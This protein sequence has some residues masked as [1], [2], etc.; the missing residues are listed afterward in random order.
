MNAGSILQEFDKRQES[1]TKL[2]EKYI[3]EM[4]DRDIDYYE[5][6]RKYAEKMNERDIEYGKRFKTLEGHQSNEDLAIEKE[7]TDGAKD[8]VVSIAQKY[9][10]KFTYKTGRNFIS[11]LSNP[12]DNKKLI[13][14]LD[15]CYILSTSAA[16]AKVE[17]VKKLNSSVQSNITTKINLHSKKLIN[18]T[19]SQTERK[20]SLKILKNTLN[21]EET[22]RNQKTANKIL[23]EERTSML[24]T[25][26]LKQPERIICII[27]AKSYISQEYIEDQKQKMHNLIDYFANANLYYQAKKNGKLDIINIAEKWTNNFD[28]TCKQFNMLFDGIIIIIGGPYSSKI[29]DVLLA[30]MKESFFKEFE[31]KKIELKN[32]IDSLPKD[33]TY[34]I[35]RYIYQC[36]LDYILNLKTDFYVLL[37]DGNRFKSDIVNI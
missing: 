22:A 3:K 37:N 28:K 35:F 8:F 27:E 16:N 13:T 4:N 7:I 25:I 31:Y 6:N 21:M 29:I 1:L 26:I 12:I 30:N 33:N 11:T 17:N 19:I 34:D 10:L 2:M 20:Q 32:K 15:G 24:S 18:S 36:N 14:N 9:D 23:N 5:R